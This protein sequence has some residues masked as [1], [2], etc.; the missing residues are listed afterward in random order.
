M[1]HHQIARFVD[2]NAM[3]VEP[4]VHLRRRPRLHEVHVVVVFDRPAASGANSSVIDAP[5]GLSERMNSGWRDPAVH[6][7]ATDRLVA[8]AQL[9]ENVSR[10]R[11]RGR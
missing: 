5:G 11:D 3:R 7:G 10:H 1:R 4:V 2:R 6:A 9:S 8:A